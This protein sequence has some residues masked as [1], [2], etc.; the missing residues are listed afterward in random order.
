MIERIQQHVEK[1][2]DNLEGPW[3]LKSSGY[4][5]EICDILGMIGE[6]STYWDAMWDTYRFEFK[7]GRGFWLDLT[8]Y[9]KVLLKCDEAACQEATTLFFVP[10]PDR[11]YIQEVIGAETPAL[12]KFLKLRKSDARSLIKLKSRLPRSFN[13]QARLSVTDVKKIATFIVY[14][15]RSQP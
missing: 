13:A 7:K 5:A 4:E 2:M 1:H 11:N 9:S 14:R 15:E 6:R 10:N 12:L 8:R 3:V